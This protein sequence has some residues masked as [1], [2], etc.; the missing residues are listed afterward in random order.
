MP[1]GRSTRST[2]SSCSSASASHVG[3]AIRQQRRSLASNASGWASTQRDRSSACA[4]GDREPVGER[5]A[6]V[7]AVG[8]DGG[9]V[10]RDRQAGVRAAQPLVQPR[11]G[12]GDRGPVQP[13]VAVGAG[14]A[15]DQRADGG[16]ASA[17]R[18]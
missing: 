14:L 5:A 18:R 16:H 7:V 15:V 8:V 11:G 13:G 2:G 17:G 9:V 1:T 4:A 12:D 3:E 6:L 10:E